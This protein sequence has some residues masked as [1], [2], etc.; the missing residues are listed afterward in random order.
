[1][2]KNKPRILA[3]GAHP[4]DIE[5]YCG[6]TLLKMGHKGSEIHHLICTYGEGKGGDRMRENNEACEFLR[7]KKR[8]ALGLFD[9]SLRHDKRLITGIDDVIRE[10]QPDWIFTHSVNDYHQDHIAVARATK[11]ANRRQEAT[12]I[13]YPPYDLAIPFKANLFVD[14]DDYFD[15]KLEL[16]KIFKSQTKEWYMRPE[17]V[18]ARSL[19]TNIATYVEKFGV[20]LMRL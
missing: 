6:G 10:V 20:E 13:V 14:I 9:S 3:I 2:K 15:K 17:V 18:E 7:V 16:L 8:Y 1:M 4:D 12:L 5:L 19:G 11:S